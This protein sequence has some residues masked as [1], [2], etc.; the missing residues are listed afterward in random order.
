MKTYILYEDP[1]DEG[2]NIFGAF[3]TEE[4]A[5]EAHK[6]FSEVGNHELYIMELELD[7]LEKYFPEAQSGYWLYYG[8]RT[9]SDY[10]RGVSYGKWDFSACGLDSLFEK[11]RKTSVV[12]F[13]RYV[14]VTIKAKSKEE[15]EEIA[16]KILEEKG[17]GYTAWL[18]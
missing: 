15:A 18:G 1:Y 10:G 8:Y 9:R 13:S 12:E 16:N 2:A 5:N 6:I 4:R 11:D 17:D 3:S 14:N 7:R